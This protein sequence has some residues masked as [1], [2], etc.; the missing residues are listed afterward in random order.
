MAAQT[1]PTFRRR[2]LGRRLRLLRE[3]AGLSLEDAAP[4]L[5]KTRSSLNRV[6]TGETRAD[7][8]LVRSMM[9]LY[10]QRDDIL[11]DLARD[12]AKKGWWRA[13][14]V[15]DLGYVDVE[16]EAV[17]VREF[18]GL[19]IP[20]LLQ[21]EDYVRALLHAGLRRSQQQIENEVAVRTI[22]QQR[23]TDESNPLELTAIIDEAA[24]LREVG[25]HAVMAGQLRRLV[26]AS[27]LPMVSVQV[28]PLRGGAHDA[29]DGG[30][31]VLEFP[32][33]DDTDLLY[34]EYPTGA[35]H[36]EKDEQVRAATLVFDRLRSQAL[37]PDDSVALIESQTGSWN[38]T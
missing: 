8:H 22:R 23:L 31:I 14:G 24:L 13:Y 34:I 26:E 29:M 33:A 4:L 6:E 28:L 37:P 15:A 7:V 19:N 12:A 27:A 20:G 21:T 35:H 17:T 1:S 32:E 2:K 11:L 10:D 9:D 38:A 3:S 5:D 25:G 16:T 30:F 18:A 36:V